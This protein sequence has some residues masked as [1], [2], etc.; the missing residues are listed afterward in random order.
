MLLASL[1]D[2][3]IEMPHWARA[4]AIIEG[5]RQGLHHL[6]AVVTDAQSTIAESIE[7]KVIGMIQEHGPLTARH[8][9]QNTRGLNAEAA[10]KLLASLVRAGVLEKI[11]DGRTEKFF[12]MDEPK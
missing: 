12:L 6:Y 1:A 11:V 2:S 10:N 3:R 9:Y 8:I 4:Q 5:W 7:D